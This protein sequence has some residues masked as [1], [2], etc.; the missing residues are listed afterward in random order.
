LL[1]GSTPT[2]A[3]P[4]DALVPYYIENAVP[5]NMLIDTST[6]T[7]VQV[8]HGYDD[9]TVRQIFDAYADPVP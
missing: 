8:L 4:V 9:A 3:D 5:M 2:V 7:I 6:M 1:L